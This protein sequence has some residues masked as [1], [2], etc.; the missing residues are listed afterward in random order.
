MDA[1]NFD[2]K[3]FMTGQIFILLTAKKQRP[4]MVKVENVTN[5]TVVLFNVDDHKLLPR[6]EKSKFHKYYTIL[7]IVRK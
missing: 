3:N 2:T 1:Q 4:I 5:K 6:M 7:E